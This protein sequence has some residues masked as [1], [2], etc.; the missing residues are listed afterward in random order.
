MFTERKNECGRGFLRNR[1]VCE[2]KQRLDAE[3]NECFFPNMVT[4]K[5]KLKFHFNGKI[6]FMCFIVP[7]EPRSGAL[8]TD[9]SEDNITKKNLVLVDRLF[10]VYDIAETVI[11]IKTV[12]VSY[13]A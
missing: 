6:S 7:D 5:I 12:C 8:K 1:K 10:M 3:Y 9:T 2:F 11:G 13:L 4:V